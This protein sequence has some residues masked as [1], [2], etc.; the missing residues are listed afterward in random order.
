VTYSDR[1]LAIATLKSEFPT[2]SDEAILA[3]IQRAYDD[4]LWSEDGYISEESVE[5]VMD[6]VEK[7]GVYTDGYE[8]SE[9]I[10]MQFV[11]D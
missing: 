6:V 4:F 3:S 7:T 2:L 5:K 10:D 11:N 9:L 8:Y 1:E